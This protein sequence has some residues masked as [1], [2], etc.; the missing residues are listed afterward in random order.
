[1]TGPRYSDY[2]GDRDSYESDLSQFEN[3]QSERE[4]ISEDDS[5]IETE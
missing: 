2:D 3:E 5:T 1:M 4:D